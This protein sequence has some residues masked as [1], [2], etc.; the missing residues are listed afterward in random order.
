MHRSGNISGNLCA[1]IQSFKILNEHDPR[2]QWPTGYE[3]TFISQCQWCWPDQASGFSL[4]GL[5]IRD[6][7]SEMGGG[8]EVRVTHV[9]TS[10]APGF[11]FGGDF[12]SVSYLCLYELLF[13]L[14]TPPPAPGYLY[15]FKLKIH[16][17]LVS[18]CV[19][20]T[21]QSTC[22]LFTIETYLY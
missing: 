14:R 22:L 2:M 9:L 18:R 16:S 1:N 7:V 19:N 20:L 12:H 4:A 10:R 8:Q 15:Q 13:H 5:A 6:K 17:S 3:Q 11:G 21:A